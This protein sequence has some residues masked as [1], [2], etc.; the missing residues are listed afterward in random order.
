MCFL[1]AYPDH[2]TN[3]II[4]VI[5]FICVRNPIRF[6]ITCKFLCFPIILYLSIGYWCFF[7]R[8]V[9]P[10][11]YTDARAAT[12]PCFFTFC[13]WENLLASLPSFTSGHKSS[14]ALY[15]SVNDAVL[16]RHSWFS[17][18]T[19]VSPPDVKSSP[20]SRDLKEEPGKMAPSWWVL[21]SL[22]YQQVDLPP[23]SYWFVYTVGKGG[24]CLHENVLSF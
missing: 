7:R 11:M 19:V 12:I 10:F 20:D 3:T 5:T 4:H 8:S 6:T 22:I 17:S 23:N 9:L 24:R 16:K 18:C 13:S 15:L 2:E 21:C 14:V 1:D